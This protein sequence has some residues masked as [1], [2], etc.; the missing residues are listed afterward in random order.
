M[1]FEKIVNKK[2]ISSVGDLPL[3]NLKLLVKK[4][5]LPDKILFACD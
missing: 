5:I 1:G 3:A 2:K 4:L